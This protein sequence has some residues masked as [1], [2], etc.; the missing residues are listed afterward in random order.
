MKEERYFYAPDATLAD[1]LPEDEAFHAIRVLRL[2]VGDE[3]MLIDGKGAFHKA[4]ITAASTK[5]CK[6]RIT[7]TIQQERQ[8]K[9]RFHIGIAPTK[10]ID[11]MEWMIEKVTEVGID[12]VSFLDCKFS[13]RRVLKTSRLDKIVISAMKQSRKAWKPIMN[14]MEPFGKFVSR[15]LSG[16]KFIAHCYDE[17]PRTFLLD[18]LRHTCEGS[19][20]TVLIGPEGDFSID[21]VRMAIDKGYVPVHLGQSRLRTETAAVASLM[22]MQLARI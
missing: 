9:E 2:K 6:Y 15:P 19:H 13:E 8:W 5:H 12:E 14:D 1:E 11:R 7:D 22:M 4:D 18:E 3:I 16:H 10:M 20:I 21:E 17:I